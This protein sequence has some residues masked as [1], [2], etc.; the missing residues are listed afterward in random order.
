MLNSQEILKCLQYEGQKSHETEATQ[1]SHDIN[2]VPK[3]IFWF[4]KA[5]F[6]KVMNI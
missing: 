4:Q 1:G 6:F 3:L 5:I 2:G